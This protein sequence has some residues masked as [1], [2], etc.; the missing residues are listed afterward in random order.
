MEYS[1]FE[2][3]DS[4]EQLENLGVDSDNWLTFYRKEKTNWIKFYPFNEYHGG[5]AP[6]IINIGTNDFDTW[7]KDY[8]DFVIEVRGLIKTK[9]Q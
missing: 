4:F 3:S 1:F 7:L 5:G 8:K 6:Y 9:V 2:F